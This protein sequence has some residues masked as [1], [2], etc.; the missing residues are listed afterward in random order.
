MSGLRCRRRCGD[1]CTRPTLPASRR[2]LQTLQHALRRARRCAAA[3]CRCAEVSESESISLQSERMST[4]DKVHN[5]VPMQVDR[6]THSVDL[7]QQDVDSGRPHSGKPPAA[8]AVV[9]GRVV[10]S[11]GHGLRLHLAEG[12]SG[13][14][15]LCDIHDVYA[16]NALTGATKVCS[17]LSEHTVLSF[18]AAP[19][20]VGLCDVHGVCADN[21]LTGEMQQ[22]SF[23]T[24][25]PCIK[26]RATNRCCTDRHTWRRHRQTRLACHWTAPLASTC[27]TPVARVSSDGWNSE[28]HHTSS[29]PLFAMH[30]MH[31]TAIVLKA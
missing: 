3:C 21:V 29:R 5:I 14:V 24:A 18:V 30:S 2:S 13:A 16:D 19:G 26:L 4:R 1:G 11:G 17:Q 22:V 8:G 10:A 12:H 6:A 9:T 28:E 7:S 20:E 25:N 23:S 15:G 31:W 27:V